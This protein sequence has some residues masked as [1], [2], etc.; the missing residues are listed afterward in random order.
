M[1]YNPGEILLNEYRIEKKIGEGAFGEVYLVTNLSLKVQRAVKVLRQDAPGLGSQEFEGSRARFQLE[2]QLGAQL[3]NPTANPHLLQV[4]SFKTLDG[5][6]LLEME[7]APGGNLEHRLAKLRAQKESMPIAEAL[8]T[9]VEVALGLAALHASNIVHRD[10]KPSNILFDEHGHARVA[11]LGLAQTLGDYSQRSQ[12]SDSLAPQHPGTPLYMSPEQANTRR[13]LQSASD[14]YALGV[15]LFEMLTGKNYNLLK[16]GTRAASLRKDI[17]ADL[18]KL[19]FQMLSDIPK[20]RPW[21]GAEAARLL[22]AVLDKKKKSFPW[23]LLI[24]GLILAGCCGS[25]AVYMLWPKPGGAAPVPAPILPTISVSLPTSQAI[26]PTNIPVVP[27]LGQVSAPATAAP[28]ATSTPA[29]TA[30]SGPGIGSTFVRKQDGMS[31]VFVPAGKFTMGSGSN[32]P[33]EQPLHT[34][35][36]S[37]FWIDQTD[38]TNAMFKTFTQA[39]NY[40]TQ[41]EVDGQADVFNTSAGFVSTT[42]AD[43]QHPLGPGSS[44]TGLDDH[45]VVQVSWQDASSYCAWAGASLPSEAQWEKAAR[46]PQAKIYPWGNQFNSNNANYG[47]KTGATSSVTQYQSGASPYGAYDMAGNVWQWVADWY[48]ENYYQASPANDPT[49]PGAGT[50]RGVRGGSWYNAGPDVRTTIRG[51]G[52]PSSSYSLIGFRCVRSGQ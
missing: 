45:P 6:L 4:H 34:V 39:L 42:G 40:K 28:A 16:P 7:Y 17:P 46:G 11:D 48:S 5:L 49:G 31:M 36:L 52:V 30:T 21:D 2:A 26:S 12:L 18:D 35:N 20:E 27:T 47:Q 38:V 9:A 24:T 29:A 25:I 3:N 51:T 19:L 44:L 22:Q 8:Q 43:W 10:L 14:I 1:T 41:A 50:Y 15:V 13:G 33:R 32:D 23:W 37:A